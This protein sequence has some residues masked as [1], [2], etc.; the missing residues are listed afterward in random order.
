MTPCRGCKA[1]FAVIVRTIMPIV[2]YDAWVPGPPVCVYWGT[3]AVVCPRVSLDILSVCGINTLTHG[4]RARNDGQ[5][6][7]KLR[8]QNRSAAS[9][10]LS[11]SSSRKRHRPPLRGLRLLRCSRSRAGQVRDA[12]ARSSRRTTDHRKRVGVRLVAPLVLSSPICLRTRRARRS[13]AEEART[14]AC[15]QAEPRGRRVSRT[16]PAWRSVLA[17]GGAGRAIARALRARGPS[18]QHRTS[19]RSVEKKRP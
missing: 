2:S 19:A 14:S 10:E 6:E 16:A 4:A 1:H 12:P 17:P 8:P 18:S 3:M 13:L 5:E 9:P 15:P 11:Q 7:Q